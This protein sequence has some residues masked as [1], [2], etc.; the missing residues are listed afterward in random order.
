MKIKLLS[1]II[2]TSLVFIGCD[3]SKIEYCNGCNDIDCEEYAP[4][5]VSVSWIGYNNPSE[6]TDYFACH[7]ATLTE[8][9]GDTIRL[10]GWVYYPDEGEPNYIY[11]EDW[12][13]DRGWILLVDNEDHHGYNQHAYVKWKEWPNY[14]TAADSAW[15]EANATFRDHFNEYLQKKWYVVAEVNEVILNGAGCC[16]H[17]PQFKIIYIDTIP[18]QL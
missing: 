3:K 1:T 11:Q 5:G 16:D 17:D 4:V 18:L 10:A 14:T 13:V 8:H 12:N 7:R 9:L 15:L 6:L 2:L